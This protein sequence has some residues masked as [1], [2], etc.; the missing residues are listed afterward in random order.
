M[1]LSSKNV[2]TWNQRQFKGE[3]IYVSTVGPSIV[4]SACV[5]SELPLWG[6]HHPAPVTMNLPAVSSVV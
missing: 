6:C 5:E 1:Q 2:G 3:R 4:S